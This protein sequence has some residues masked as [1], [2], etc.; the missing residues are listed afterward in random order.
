M[1]PANLKFLQDIKEVCKKNNLLLFLDEVQSGF[2]RSG[3]LF[4]HQ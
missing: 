1:R 4:A 2:G 3:K